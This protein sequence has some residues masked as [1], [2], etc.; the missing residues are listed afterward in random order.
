MVEIAE[1]SKVTWAVPNVYFPPLLC[2]APATVMLFP[3]GCGGGVGAS[4]TGGAGGGAIKLDV[5]GSLTIDGILSADGTDGVIGVRTVGGGSGGSIWITGNGLLVGGGTISARGGAGDSNFN[6]W[7]GGSGGGGG[8]IDLSGI[9]VAGSTFL[10]GGGSILLDGGLSGEPNLASIQ[11]GAAGSINFPSS[12]DLVID[13]SGATGMRSMIMGPNTESG[14]IVESFYNFNSITVVANSTLTLAG[15]SQILNGGTATGPY[16]QGITLTAT[17]ITINANGAILADGQGIAGKERGSAYGPG[18]GEG[19]SN[20]GAG[21]GYG[22]DGGV[23]GSG[24]PG[25]SYGNIT[26]PTELGSGGGGEDDKIGGAGGGG[27]KLIVSGTLTNNGTLS[28]D[29]VLG[30]AGGEV[31]GGSGGSLHLT[32]GTIAGSGIIS[33]NGS[34][35]ITSG[36]DDNGGGGGGRVAVYYTVSNAIIPTVYGGSGTDNATDG[37]AGTVYIESAADGTGNGELIIDNNNSSNGALTKISQFTDN[38]TIGTATIRN[39]GI[40]EMSHST[41]S[42]TLSRDWNNTATQTLTNGTVIFASTYSQTV[43]NNGQNFY[44][45][46]SSNTNSN[47]LTFSSSFTAN[48]LLV[49]TNDLT[50]S[51]TLY[52]AGNSTFTLTQFIITGTGAKPVVL[53]STASGVFWYVHTTIQNVSEVEVEDS[54]ASGGSTIYAG[55]ASTGTNTVNWIFADPTDVGERHWV[56]VSSGVWSDT[57]NWDYVVGGAGGASPPASTHTVIFNSGGTAD[58]YIDSNVTVT[59]MTISNYPGTLFSQSFNVTISSHYGQTGGTISLGTSAVT[60]QGDFVRSG[61]TFIAGT[62]TMTLTGTKTQT[63]T[64]G[65]TGFY[66]LRVNKTGGTASPS[67]ALRL[68]GDL[69]VSLGTLDGGTQTMRVDGEIIILGGILDA[70]SNSLSGGTFRHTAGTFNNNN[71]I[72]VVDGDGT[73]TI[74]VSAGTTFNHFSVND[75]LIG[76]WKLDDSTGSA[77]AADSS[78]YGS[79][80][81]LQDMDPNVDWVAGSTQ[82]QFFNRSAL[83]FSGGNDYIRVENNDTLNY[84]GSALSITAWVKLP[85]GGF[86]NDFAVVCKGP[87][88]SSDERY[89]LGVKNN[90]NINFRTTTDQNGYVA[91]SGP[92]AGVPVDQWVHIAGTYDGTTMRMYVNGVIPTGGT[93]SQNGNISSNTDFLSLGKR[94][95]TDNR[96][97]VGQF[98]EVRIY[99]FALSTAAVQA[100]ANGN[101]PELANST[102]SISGADLNVDGDL[103][104]NDGNLDPNGNNITVAGAW[105]QNGGVFEYG[106]SQVTFDGAAISTITASTTFYDLILASSLTEMQ[107]SEKSTFTVTNSVNF[108]SLNLRS[109]TDGATWYLNGNGIAQTIT[110]VDVQDSNASGDTLI[111]LAVSTDSGNNTNW[112]FSAGTFTWTNANAT[113]LW[114]DGANWTP[115]GPPSSGSV[116]LFDPVSSTDSVSIDQ[117]YSP[118]YSITLMEGYLG[119][120]TFTVNAVQASASSQTLTL[121]GDLIVT[122]GT[123]ALT[124][125][126]GRTDS[127]DAIPS[128]SILD[129]MGWTINANNI[130]ISS[131]GIVHADG[132]GY[133]DSAGPGNGSY[134]SGGTHGGGGFI[135]GDATYGSFT[136]PV[137]LG[138]GGNRSGNKGG[139]AI[140]LSVTNNL[141]INGILSADGIIVDFSDGNGAGAGGS[142]NLSANILV[143]SGTIRT[144]GGSPGAVSNPG[145]GGGGRIGLNGITTDNFSGTLEVLGGTAW[146][147]IL[148]PAPPPILVLLELPPPLALMVPFTVTVLVATII[149]A[150]PPVPS[151]VFPPLPMSLRNYQ[152]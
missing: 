72:V 113:N 39:A 20:E 15:N 102:Y 33:A 41:A 49:N 29:G 83:D 66:H 31:A 126:D 121:A 69:T 75:G 61:G 81:N 128:N 3:L 136:N 30:T 99:N 142:L 146:I 52:F 44:N 7:D 53:K 56:A 152:W 47:G 96:Y 110:A 98:D 9:T 26:N 119:I 42:I 73:Q 91:I 106:T 132:L 43:N 92:A 90:E 51:A 97:W 23:D 16:G 55:P 80:G 38:P 107:F 48:N 21:G 109:T 117:I 68:N 77:T 8:R 34:D 12:F 105:Q 62:S 114:S 50:S 104:L 54:D 103:L 2:Q 60:L 6:N 17:N 70:T 36:I 118:L 37:G 63:L 148:P 79:T 143:G 18:E 100:L 76:Y 141:T 88:V 57:A 11:D 87:G 74:D 22:G 95:N 84:T 150:P 58:S 93:A 64:Q 78:G 85:P 86:S 67:Q 124:G 46:T 120:A 111:A 4:G 5:S 131:N 13:N 45:I 116:V 127:N 108:Q 32:A 135:N 40:L 144:N 115:A 82:T 24:F 25:T 138:S 137:S 140:T 129:G 14:S 94:C 139:G 10:T 122:S 71:G 145:G 134:G 19:E 133:P 112:I 28:A 59:T 27:I 35:G 1:P 147:L 65:G 151:S 125:D 130:T 89:M 123:I 101:Q 149:T